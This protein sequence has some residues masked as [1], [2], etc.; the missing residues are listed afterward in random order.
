MLDIMLERKQNFYNKANFVFFQTLYSLTY[1]M[2][3]IVFYYYNYP[4]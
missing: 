1:F 4:R 3:Y 2:Y